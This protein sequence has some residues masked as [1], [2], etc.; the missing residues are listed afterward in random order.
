M[1]YFKKTITAL[2]VSSTLSIAQVAAQPNIVVIVSDDLNYSGLSFTGNSKVKTP[3]IDSI[4]QDGVFFENGYVTHAVCA[5]SRAG[6][7]T[8][9]YQAR[10]GYE[11]L[12]SNDKDGVKHDIG[13]DTREIFLSEVLK[14]AGYTTAAFGKWH[15]GVNEKYQPYNRGFDYVY[16][17]PGRCSYY[18]WDSLRIN[19]VEVS[20]REEDKIAVFDHKGRQRGDAYT[21]EALGRAAADFIDKKGS[22][23]FFLYFGSYNVHKPLQVPLEYIPEG[24]DIYDGMV[25]AL[26]ANVGTILNAIESNGLED[27]TLMFFV[28]DNGGTKGH[29][30]GVFQGGKATN[31]EGGIRVPFGLKWPEKLSGG[32]NF[33]GITSTMDIFPTAVA[34][35]GAEMPVDRSY[36]GVDLMP[37]LLGK[38]AGNPHETLFW[39]SGYGHAMRMGKY[40]L[41]WMADKKKSMANER[42]HYG[43]KKFKWELPLYKD[44]HKTY[45][46]PKLFDLSKDPGEQIDISNKFPEI[47]EKM[48]RQIEGF[49][50]EMR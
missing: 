39:R 23:P 45:M 49:D 46:A 16:G 48:I 32:K 33:T 15:L 2:M 40:K 18:N 43:R 41:L 26:D 28:N 36:D 9:R 3:N 27:N 30:N 34:A 6:M 14:E 35:A 13:V 8:G 25:A 22:K 7:M 11:T 29:A 42:Q 20:F 47:T 5:P 17:H 38:K 21:T 4:F 24:G 1:K 31:W 19:G 50:I 44:K 37:W 12:T 10:F